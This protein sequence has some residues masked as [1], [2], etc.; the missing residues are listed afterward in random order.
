MFESNNLI[1][2]LE[3]RADDSD[4][5]ELDREVIEELKRL[6]GGAKQM[7]EVTGYLTDDNTFF[8]TA[9]QAEHH[10]AIGALKGAYHQ[11]VG[12]KGNFERFA[13]VIINLAPEIRRFLNAHEGPERDIKAEVDQ[14]TVEREILASRKTKA[15]L[16]TA[17]DGT[18]EAFEGLLQQPDRRPVHVPDLG[19]RPRSE[20]IFQRSKIDGS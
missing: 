7:R 1:K 16:Y 20:E 9:E 2:R 19:D 13:N 8:E 10:E 11:F 15:D 5:Q 4:N 12:Q 18:G 3:R 17:D 14:A 6:Q